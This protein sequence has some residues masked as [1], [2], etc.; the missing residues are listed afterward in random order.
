VV[1]IG[2]VLSKD[3][4]AVSNINQVLFRLR[5]PVVQPPVFGEEIRPILEKN[6]KIGLYLGVRHTGN[7]KLDYFVPD[8]TPLTVN[9]TC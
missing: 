9:L 6:G 4:D 8:F 2:K 1:S 5:K 3:P 7:S